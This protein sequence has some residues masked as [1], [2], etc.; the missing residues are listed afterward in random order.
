MDYLF[1]KMY[2]EKRYDILIDVFFMLRQS[3][4]SPSFL[5]R[6]FSSSIFL[7]SG[8][9]CAFLFAF[10][11]LRSYYQ[12]FH[13]RREIAML[14]QEVQSLEK[15]KLESLSLLQYV[16]TDDFVKEVARETLD[17]KEP[18]ENVMVVEAPLIYETTE[19][20]IG[21]DKPRLSNPR[22]W[23]YYFIHKDIE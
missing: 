10:A 17:Y 4:P 19:V 12:D 13:I 5:V 8:F 14:E 15:K 18:G 6:F 21:E 22:K 1:E 7:V 23:W 20:G 11:F 16:Q 3:R 2:N 9:V